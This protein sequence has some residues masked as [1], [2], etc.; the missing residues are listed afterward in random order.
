[1]KNLNIHGTFIC[2]LL[3]K[4]RLIHA[5]DSKLFKQL[6]SVVHGYRRPLEKAFCNITLN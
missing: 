5:C 4:P 6:F 2:D 1:M 3:I